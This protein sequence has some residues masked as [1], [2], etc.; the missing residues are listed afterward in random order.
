MKKYVTPALI[1]FVLLAALM[2][3]QSSY[4]VAETVPGFLPS[5]ATDVYT[6]DVRIERVYL[7]NTTGSAVT[8][9]LLDKSANCSAGACSMWPA[10]SIAANTVYTVDMGNVWFRGGL[11][12]SASAGNAVVGYLR[13]RK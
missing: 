10:V 13:A 6:S 5:S 11:Q 4:T 8:V 3:G 9:T 7:A 2:P 12:W 1:L